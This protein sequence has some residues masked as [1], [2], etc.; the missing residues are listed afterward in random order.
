MDELGDSYAR[1]RDAWGGYAGYDR[2]FNRPLNNA[3]FASI[4]TY[5]ALL[6][7]FEALLDKVDGDMQRFHVASKN[8]ADLPRHERHA[9]LRALTKT[10]GTGG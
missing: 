4:G 10:D 3:H 2:W 6:P 7:A 1:Q 5:N 8:L 9:R